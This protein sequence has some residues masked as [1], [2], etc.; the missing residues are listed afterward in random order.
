MVGYELH[1]WPDPESYELIGV[2]AERRI[3]PQRI[4]KESVL[5]WG[6]TYFGNYQN[7]NEIFFLEVEINGE[8]IRTL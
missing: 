1:C 4:T 5:N 7:L 3:N 8:S 6:K 2:L